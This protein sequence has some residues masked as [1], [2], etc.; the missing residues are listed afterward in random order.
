MIA[1]I[2]G[3]SRI[4][5][6]HYKI[7]E[8]L[9][10]K[11][12]YFISRKKKSSIIFVKKNIGNTDICNSEDYKILK[13]K[14]FDLI[15][16]CTNTKAH[17]ETIVKIQK[18]QKFLIIEKPLISSIKFKKNYLNTFNK[19]YKNQKNLVVCYPMIF[20]AKNFLKQFSYSKK[21]KTLKIYYYTN[22]RHK[23]NR[24][25]EDL[26]PHGLSLAY[27]LFKKKKFSKKYFTNLF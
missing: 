11:K 9:N 16:N 22:G 5:I 7:L 19:I 3:S 15:I 10:Y 26:L 14:K 4:A 20:L 8:K 1:A 23:F 21:I 17:F 25:S 27:I 6:I 18:N 13:K 12:I 2:I 24:I